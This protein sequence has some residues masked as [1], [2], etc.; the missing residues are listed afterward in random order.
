MDSLNLSIYAG[1]VGTYAD[2][3]ITQLEGDI[4]QG[5]LREVNYD[6]NAFGVGPGILLSFKLIESNRFMFNLIGS[7]HLVVYNEWGDD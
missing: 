5:T 7:G 2:G 3:K 1:F 6:S 4:N